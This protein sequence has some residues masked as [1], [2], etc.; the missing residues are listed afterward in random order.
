MQ[1]YQRACASKSLNIITSHG[2]NFSLQS[3]QEADP[4]TAA[5]AAQIKRA[6]LEF[7]L[8][9]AVVALKVWKTT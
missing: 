8:A 2:I 6:K 1:I 7:I 3:T 5:I 4:T 9:L